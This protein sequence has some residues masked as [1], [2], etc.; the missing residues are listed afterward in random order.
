MHRDTVAQWRKR[1]AG[2]RLAGI[3]RDAPG[4]GRKGTKRRHCARTIFDVTLH[5]TP[6]NATHWSQRSLAEHLGIDI[7]SDGWPGSVPLLCQRC[8]V[9]DL[10]AKRCCEASAQATLRLHCS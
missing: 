4:R 2:Q 10:A 9:I 3:A 5:T 1:F 7:G 6:K 8:D